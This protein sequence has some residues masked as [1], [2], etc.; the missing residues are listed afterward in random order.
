MGTIE[1]TEVP[2]YLRGENQ[3]ESAPNLDLYEA[4]ESGDVEKLRNALSQGANANFFNRQADGVLHAASRVDAAL[5]AKELISQGA[6]VSAALISNRN[7][8]IHEASSSGSKEVCNVLIQ[9]S[10]ECTQKQNSYGNTALHAAARSGHP[11]IVE[12]LLRNSADPNKINNRGSTALHIVCF[13]ASCDASDGD[14]YIRIAAMLLSHEN[15]NI[16]IADVNGYTALHVAAQ[17][18]CNDMVKLLIENG[19]SLTVKTGR[20]RNPEAMA[21]FGGHES[22]AEMIRQIAAA[23]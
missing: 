16:D 11:E 1:K 23:K 22:T 12:L 6:R 9:A 14:P 7:T 17:R 2:E 21:K 4:A 8:A 20:G 5:C 15:L 3:W 10:P 18:G 19:A 13:M